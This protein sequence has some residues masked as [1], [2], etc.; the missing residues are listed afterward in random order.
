[1]ADSNS[2]RPVHLETTEARAGSTP[3]MTRYILA[4]SLVLIIVAFLA[5]WLI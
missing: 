4:A 1:M 5:I 2:N 3:G